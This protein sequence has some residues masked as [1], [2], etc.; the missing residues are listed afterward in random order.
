MTAVMSGQQLLTVVDDHITTIGHLVNQIISRQGLVSGGTIKVDDE[1]CIARN[2]FSVAAVYRYD[3][4]RRGAQL[5][6]R[7][8]AT[9]ELR[10]LIVT[11][12]HMNR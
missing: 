3:H 2:R 6:L 1:L 4:G 9:R 12:G 5:A 11:L 8:M 10:D 7:E